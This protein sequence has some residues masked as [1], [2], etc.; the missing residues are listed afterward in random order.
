[1]DTKKLLINFSIISIIMIVLLMIIFIKALF[2]FN[3]SR[4]EYSPNDWNYVSINTM[5]SESIVIKNP[6]VTQQTDKYS[7]DEI[8]LLARLIN[9]EAK[10]ESFEGKVAV[11]NVVINRIKSGKYPDTIKKVIYQPRQFQPVSNGAINEKPSV[12]AVEAAYK[13]LNI[14]MVGNALFY[15][16]PD[17]ATDSWIRTRKVVKKIGNH[18]FSI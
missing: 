15:Y 14:N 4:I 8:H 1:M 6:Q 12:E 11:G 2:V 7:K 10:G 17:I 3:E 5:M 18:S 16:N 13:S 9:A